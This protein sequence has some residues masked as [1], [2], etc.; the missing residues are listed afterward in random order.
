MLQCRPLTLHS[1]TLKQ[2]QT[3]R[4]KLL[5]VYGVFGCLSNRLEP[6]QQ[7]RTGRPRSH[8]FA[9]LLAECIPGFWART[10]AEHPGRLPCSSGRAYHRLCDLQ[11]SLGWAHLSSG[12]MCPRGPDPLLCLATLL[13]LFSEA[14]ELQRLIDRCC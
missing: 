13:S 6:S 1:L 4:S 8:M 3:E 11:P 2:Q 14:N 9:F 5:Q 12:T 7:L 10:K